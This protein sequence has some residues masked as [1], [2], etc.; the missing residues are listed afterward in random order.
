MSFTARESDFSELWGST[1]RKYVIPRYQREYSWKED[2]LT[3]FWE[4]IHQEEDLFFGS[5]VLKNPDS[6]NSRIEIID[7]QQRM[8][9]MTILYSA[10]RDSLTELGA[11][12]EAR[13]VHST[14]IY[15]FRGLRDGHFIIQPTT[16]LK[17]YFERSVQSQQP[18]FRNPKTKEHKRVRKNY[19]WLKKE[20]KNLLV[21]DSVE[22]NLGVIED[23]V[24]RIGRMQIIR[25]TVDDS[26]DAYRIFETVNAT[27]V[28]LS[29]ADLLKNMVFRHIPENEDSGED[30][31]QRK[32][33]EM[34][35]YLAE[36]NLDV[37]RFVRYHWI[38]SRETVTMRNLYKSVK[39][40][41]SNR[42]WKE[43][44]E[45]LLD[46]SRMLNSL[47]MGTIPN[48]N[49]TRLID[50]INKRLRSIAH[51]GFSQ[52]YVLLLS[53]LRNRERLNFSW[54]EF[55]QLVS[56]IE[57]FNFIYHTICTRPANKVETFYSRKA[58]S[59]QDVDANADGQTRLRSNINAIYN[60]L[61]ILK[62]SRIE[63]IEDFK[64]S[65]QY[66][67]ST[68]KKSLIR[69]ILGRIEEKKYPG[70][71][72]ERP[73]DESI[74]IEHILPQKPQEFWGMN[75]LEAKPFVHLIGNLVLVG[76]G[77]NSS[78]RNYDI[79]RK[80]SELKRTAIKTTGDLLSKISQKQP[81]EWTRLDIENRTRDLAILSYDEL[82][83]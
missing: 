83:A 22:S 5:V 80:I 37:A 20:I 56:E 12:E 8:L 18:D 72:A 81:L 27:G 57:N 70:Q 65:T 46:D 2:N 62:P 61:N 71:V 42:G 52:C 74:S 58:I 32:W 24:E 77:F 51:M 28:D 14:R 35:E 75:E 39:G 47:M 4:D 30:P 43:L 25:I 11:E 15:Q 31:A 48:P 66:G 41:T 40:A 10:I 78:A 64:A 13:R 45:N 44:L 29:V 50:Q 68:K 67:S 21:H 38:S 82:W 59:I 9:T 69:Y 23:L 53:L 1:E 17:D 63:F 55:N 6:R 19:N 36:I 60:E 7:G 3:T 54:E 79:T 16:G 73:I 26:Y 33:T 76:Q 34:K 49:S